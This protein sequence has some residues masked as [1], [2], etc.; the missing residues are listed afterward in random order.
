[1]RQ[2]QERSEITLAAYVGRA[3]TNCTDH[4]IFGW[5]QQFL[6]M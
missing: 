6:Q 3:L 4:W 1:M 2:N 5:W